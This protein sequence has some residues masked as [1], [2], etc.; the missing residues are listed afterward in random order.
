MSLPRFEKVGQGRY[1]EV[2][3]SRR[4]L[5]LV[6]RGRGK[7]A[8]RGANASRKTKSRTRKI[9][10]ELDFPKAIRPKGEREAYGRTRRIGEGGTTVSRESSERPKSLFQPRIAVAQRGYIERR[11]YHLRRTRCLVKEVISGQDLLLSCVPQFHQLLFLPWRYVFW[12]KRCR[13]CEGCGGGGR[14]RGDVGFFFFPFLSRS[15]R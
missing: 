6:I 15:R 13:C 14:R 11:W 7:K 1:E 2:N 5:E 3:P 8:A 10:R 12:G 4:T 9:D